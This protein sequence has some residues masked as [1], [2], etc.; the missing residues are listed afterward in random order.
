ML[1]FSN[2][3]NNINNVQNNISRNNKTILYKRFK[4]KILLNFTYNL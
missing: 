3:I 2:N 4:A 1:I